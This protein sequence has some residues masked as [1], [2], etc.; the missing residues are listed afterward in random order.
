MLLLFCMCVLVF[1][2]RPNNS[3]NNI[4][5]VKGYEHII[6]CPDTPY[7]WWQEWFFTDSLHCKYANEIYYAETYEEYFAMLDEFYPIELPENATEY[8]K[9]KASV[10]QFDSLMS[11]PG[12]SGATVQIYLYESYDQAF[13]EYTTNKIIDLLKRKQLYSYDV[14]SAWR[15]Y[16]KT[17]ELVI[18]SVVMYRP[19]CLGTLSGMEFVAFT[20]FLKDGY[21]N[22]MLEFLFYREMNAPKH[23]TISDEMI[24]AAYDSLRAHQ[25]EADTE[26]DDI[27]DCYVPV[28]TRIDAI[29]QDQIAWDEFINVRNSFERNL[30]GLKKR[31]Y[32]NATNNLKWRK[33]LLLKNEYKYFGI[34]PV[35]FHGKFLPLDCSDEKLLEFDY[36]KEIVLSGNHRH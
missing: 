33:L 31:A 30:F 14:D 36:Y 28:E 7:Y 24:C 19:E 26:F 34:G 5:E 23:M 13:T 29:N 9:Y 17:M 10:I 4:L 8:D 18:D 21:L 12:H 2:I 25:F 1:V 6:Q 20:G 27:L 16:Y 11:F 3:S 35:G 15:N 22:S 32:H